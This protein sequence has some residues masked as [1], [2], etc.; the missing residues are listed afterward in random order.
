MAINGDTNTKALF[1][2]LDTSPLIDKYYNDTEYSKQIMGTDTSAQKKWLIK[3]LK[4]RD[5]NIKWTF[6]VGH[7]PLYSSGKRIKSAETLQ[8]RKSMQGIFDKFKVDAYL[9]GHEH[10]L[11]YTK[12]EGKTHYFISGAGSEK[13]DV[14]GKLPETKF[15]A[16]DHGFMTFSVSKSK[17]LFQ[18]I[19]WEGKI[20][21]SETL[22]Q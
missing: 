1:I 14:K 8:F 4:E 11:E 21:Y 7:H 16:S 3:T 20:L 12:P 19:N 18:V 13:R 2:F 15:S 10:H 22:K 9:C 6:V 5:K 17:L